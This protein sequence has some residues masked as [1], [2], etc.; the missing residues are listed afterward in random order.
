MAANSVPSETRDDAAGARARADAC[1]ILNS[2]SGKDRKARATLKRAV[3]RRSGR[4]D[5]RTVG[6]GEDIAEVAERAVKDGYVT[7]VAAGGDGTIGAVAE[8]ARAHDRTL[9]IV[10]MGTFNF[11]AR[12]LSIP[13]DPDDALDQ[14]VAGQARRIDLAEI[15]G[16]VF[17]NN[18]SLGLYPAILAEREGIYRRWGRS[19]LAAHYSVIATFLHFHRPVALNVVVDGRTIAARTPLAFVAHQRT[20]ARTLR[21]ARRR[22]RTG[23][24]ARPVP[25]A[26]RLALAPARPR[27]AAR[28]ARSEGRNGLRLRQRRAYRDR[29]R[30]PHAPHRARWRARAHA[31][32]L[33]AS[34]A[35]GC[36]AR[37]RTGGHTIT[38]RILH[39][40]DL[41]FGRDR[42][43]L[44]SPLTETINRLA[45]ISSQCRAI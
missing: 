30:E 31:L 34:C 42:P 29:D 5:L 28:P 35:Q 15:N 7:L 44:L 24:A 19:R 26:G 4:F 21:P 18:A 13:D 23:G 20:P 38:R 25:D 45:A 1:I 41:H 10:P 43:E 11:F 40:S 36:A 12:G 17:L 32:A 9:G 39:V 8:I 3:E 6:R 22:R 27:P 37:H 16:R 33:H 2:G 14:I